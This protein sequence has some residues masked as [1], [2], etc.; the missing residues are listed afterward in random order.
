MSALFG[1]Q[2]GISLTKAKLSKLNLEKG[3]IRDLTKD[4]QTKYFG[5][6]MPQST[7]NIKINKYG[8]MTRDLN[9]RILAL[10]ERLKRQGEKEE[11]EKK[12]QQQQ[13]K[14]EPQ[15]KKK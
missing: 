12:Q 11:K 3:V 10:E 8:E 13:Q 5:G 15:R 7:Y 4:A 6:D 1:R 9:R 14:K 2:I